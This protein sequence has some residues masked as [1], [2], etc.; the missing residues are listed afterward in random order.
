MQKSHNKKKNWNCITFLKIKS[1]WMSVKT[2]VLKTDCA[3]QDI[4][5]CRAIL[6][7]TQFDPIHGHT[8]ANT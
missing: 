1:Y 8:E 7:K 5:E 3:S 4:A 2:A 6:L